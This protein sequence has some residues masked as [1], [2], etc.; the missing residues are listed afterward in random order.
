MNNDSFWAHFHLTVNDVP[1][2]GLLLPHCFSRCL[3]SRRGRLFPP[4]PIPD[5]RHI[6]AVIAYVLFVFDQFIPHG[7][8]QIGSPRSNVR[9]TVDHILHQVKSVHVVQHRHIESRGDRAFFLI[10]PYMNILMIRPSVG[11]TMDQPGIAVKGGHN[12]RR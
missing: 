9:Q 3:L 10:S 1:I 7:L 8:F 5:L 2:L 6:D 12:G 11:E 4:F